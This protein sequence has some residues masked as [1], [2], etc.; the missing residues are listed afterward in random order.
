MAVDTT[1]ALEMLKHDHREVE[2]LF[3]EYES[4]ADGGDTTAKEAVAAEIC[5]M[6][7][8]H[9]QVE[10]EVFYPAAR[11][12]LEQ[13]EII[14]DAE[15]EHANAKQLISELEE[16]SAEDDTF[17]AR[18]KALRDAIIHH[19]EEEEGEMFAKLKEAGMETETLGEQMAERKQEILDELG[20]AEVEE[21]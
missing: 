7:T 19:V 20:L 11:Q 13:A 12:V 18:V 4:L 16:L 14:N 15:E 1:D 3:A 6:L 5:E 2:T 21:D 17:D 10:E 9:A 8:V